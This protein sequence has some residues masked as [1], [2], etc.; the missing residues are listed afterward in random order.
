M[1]STIKEA[2]SKK[3]LG[4]LEAIVNS[5]NHIYVSVDGKLFSGWQASRD[6]LAADM[7]QG[8]I[9][10]DDITLL[11]A[12]DKDTV[13]AFAKA[14]DDVTASFRF[15]KLL[16]VEWK[17]TATDLSGKRLSFSVTSLSKDITSWG[18]VKQ[19]SLR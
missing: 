19:F 11:I 1:V 10:L 16:D 17:I 3:D 14:G 12:L 9:K 7:K 2:Y 6:A 13:I 15:E 8:N 5:V 4:T 18:D